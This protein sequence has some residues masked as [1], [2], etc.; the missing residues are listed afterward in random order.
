MHDE[1][2]L[3]DAGVEVRELGEGVDRG[4]A[5]ER[6]VGE[7][8]ALGAL[9]LV[10][11]RE[12]GRVDVGEVDLDHAEGVRADALAHHHVG[13][14]ELADLGQP[15]GRVALAGR[16]RRRRGRSRGRRL[17][18]R[19]GRR[20]GL[21]CR[22][23][24]GPRRSA[25]V[26]LPARLGAVLSMWSSTSSRVMRP[27][28]PRAVDRRRV[29]AVLVDQ[30]PDD[31]RQQDAL[32]RHGV[33]SAGC[34]AAGAGSAGG[35]ASWP[36]RAARPPVPAPRRPAPPLRPPVRAGRG[37]LGGAGLLSR[38]LLGGRCRGTPTAHH[39][40]R[41]RSRCRPRRSRPLGP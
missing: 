9:P 18:G 41:R 37:L 7:A 10:L 2:V 8:E 24:P 25:R 29:E 12:A 1:L 33:A 6:Q 31:R 3:G 17:R 27:P 39:R 30:P 26:R 23:Q 16:H 28:G 15:D 19:R 35:A 36:R 32:R 4:P 38:R 20:R 11:D 5:D 13:A 14:G 21:G 22:L 40:R 34:S